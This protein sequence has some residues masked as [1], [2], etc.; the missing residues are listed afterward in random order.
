VPAATRLLLLGGTTEASG[1]A[2]R[3]AD[4]PAW[5]VTTSLAGRTAKPAPLPGAVRVG[6]FGGSTGLAT[7]LRAQ[8]VDVVVDATHPFAA[9]MRWHAFEACDLVGVPRLRIERPPWEAQPDDAWRHVESVAE[10][11]TLLAA[12]GAPGPSSRVFLSTGRVDL[13][14]F[15]PAADGERWFLIRSIDPPDPQ[16]LAPAEVVLAK[17]PFALDDELALMRRH[18]IDL[19]VSK[20]SGGTAAAAKLVAA[21]ELRVPVLIVDRPPSPPGPL[22]ETVE[23]AVAWLAQLAASAGQVG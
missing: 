18:R 5:E 16:P 17:G 2:R 23:H 10:A 21:R 3:L 7:Y 12:G 6:G 11:G 14:A 8:A 19:L 4:D 1:L 13:S 20:N 9:V 15:A 22:V